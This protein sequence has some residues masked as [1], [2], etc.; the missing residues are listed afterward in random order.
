MKPDR[1]RIQLDLTP[2]MR[3]EVDQL[4]NATGAATRAE[5]VRRAVSVYAALLAEL[6][7]G[8]QVE[9]VGKNGRDR[10]RLLMP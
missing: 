5:V 6:N 3:D 7:G 10:R 8:R 4:A 2:A 1:I 9:T